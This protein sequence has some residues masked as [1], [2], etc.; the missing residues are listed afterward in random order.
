MWEL[1]QCGNSKIMIAFSYLVGYVGP[2]YV[3]GGRYCKRDRFS[4]SLGIHRDGDGY[5]KSL[6]RVVA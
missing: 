2:Q 3:D 4:S 1:G 5:A 6:E